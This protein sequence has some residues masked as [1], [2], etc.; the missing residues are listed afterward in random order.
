LRILFL[1]PI[2]QLGGA[3][4]SLLDLIRSLREQ[5]SPPDLSLISFSEGPLVDAVASLN[6]DVE[7]VSLPSGHAALGDSGFGPRTLLG[8]AQAAV[9]MRAF[10]RFLERLRRVITV[11]GPDLIHSNGFKAHLISG[12]IRPAKAHL[13]WHVRDFI[14]SR[15][16]MRALLPRLESRASA[17]ICISKAVAVDARTVL[18][19]TRILTVLNGVNTQA[20]ADPGIPPMDLDA[21]AGLP[22]SKPNVTRVGLLATNA[23][24]KGHGLFVDA[25]SR[26]RDPRA[27]FYIIGGSIYSTSKS[28]VDTVSLRRKVAGFALD[29]RCGFVPFQQDSR[30]I[31][32]ALDIVVNASTAPEPFGRTVAEGMAAGRAVV[33]PDAGG[34]PEQVSDRVTGRLFPSGNADA[35]AEALDALIASPDERARLG[36][37]AAV[38][39]REHLDARRLGPEVLHI[40]QAVLNT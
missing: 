23:K 39:A 21:L 10:S 12:W 33:A 2:G 3:E 30:G 19:K 35:L 20:F 5:D 1:N 40:Y 22:P 37:A 27:R 7:V 18:R 9:G 8:L 6:V 38:H 36:R 24:W 34:I 15:P 32:R 28:Q 25:A 11:R 4:R 26:C 29:E 16:M 31:Y 17:A 13:I 14:S